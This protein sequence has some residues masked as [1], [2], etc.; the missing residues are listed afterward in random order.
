MKKLLLMA[1]SLMI[2][3]AVFS[4]SDNN[5]EQDTFLEEKTSDWIRVD[6]P[7]PLPTNRSISRANSVPQARPRV[8]TT[9]KPTAT[10]PR[11]SENFSKTNSQVGR[12]KKGKQN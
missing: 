3:G 5:R 10:Q 2:G 6:M 8:T 12:F 11:S 7:A 9:V 1:F 4:Q